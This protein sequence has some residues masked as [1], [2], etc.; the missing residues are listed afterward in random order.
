MLGDKGMEAVAVVIRNRVLSNKFPNNIY[1]VLTQPNQFT[2]I[3]HLH[4]YTT[5]SSILAV[6]PNIQT[7]INNVFNN[8]VT[9]SVQPFNNALFF[10]S[11]YNNYLD[12]LKWATYIGKQDINGYTHYFFR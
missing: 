7:I 8:V 5:W 11:G 9:A 12:F 6:E 2:T 1:D 3:G 4:D 10:C